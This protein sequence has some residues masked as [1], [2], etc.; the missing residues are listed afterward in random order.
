MVELSSWN[1][2][3]Y[4]FLH[5]SVYSFAWLVFLLQMHSNYMFIY[6][7]KTIIRI[8]ADGSRVASI[9]FSLFSLTVLFVSLPSAN[10]CTVTSLARLPSWLLLS[11]YFLE[12]AIEVVAIWLLNVMPSTFV[13]LI[14]WICKNSSCFFPGCIIFQL[15]CYSYCIFIIRY[16]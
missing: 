8:L 16:G 7:D 11:S 15:W 10:R 2:H 3:G 9:L 12:I 6:D 14:G 13:F 5:P 1:T 4:S